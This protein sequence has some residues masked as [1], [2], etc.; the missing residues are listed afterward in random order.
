[1][2]LAE[3]EHIAIELR[4]SMWKVGMDFFGSADDAEDVAQE[5]LVQLWQ[6]AEKLD[7]GRNIS[8]LA[9]RIAKHCCVDMQ[10]KRRGNTVELMPVHERE[11]GADASPHEELERTEAAELL[12]QLIEELNPRERELF[13]LRQLDGLSN[14]EIAERTGIPKTSIQVMVSRARKKIFDELQRKLKN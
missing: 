8:G 10:R 13:E 12:Q 4:P 14:D 1:M 3:F 11:I 9:V 5:A 2:T 6:Y 7:A